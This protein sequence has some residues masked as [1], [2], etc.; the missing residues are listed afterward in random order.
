MRCLDEDSLREES[1]RYLLPY[2]GRRVERI[3][4][5]YALTLVLDGSIALTIECPAVLSHGPITAPDA[6][7]HH[8]VPDRQ[9]V[10]QALALFGAEVLSSVAFKSG[11]LRAVFSNGLH[12][13]VA[14]SNEFEAWQACGPGTLRVVSLPGGD[15]AVWR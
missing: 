3:L 2:R 10:D 8:V 9:Q 13:N 15:L 5:D 11:A 6:V 14:A 12:L 1:D 4:V 7:P